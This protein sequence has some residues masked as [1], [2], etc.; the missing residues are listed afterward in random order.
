M[1]ERQI[2]KYLQ[3]SCCLAFWAR[4]FLSLSFGC[5]AA[6]GLS[7]ESVSYKSK[8]NRPQ[9]PVIVVAHRVAISAR[10]V[11]VSMLNQTHWTLRACG[12]CSS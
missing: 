12:A 4:S 9:L 1:R 11:M 2:L 8:D 5:A 6:G 10:A 7:S 3:P